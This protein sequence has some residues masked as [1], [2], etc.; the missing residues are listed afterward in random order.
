MEGLFQ[1]HLSTHLS[2]WYR[3]ASL[4]KTR[5][6]S[7]RSDLGGIPNTSYG[8]GALILPQTTS[9]KNQS[10][11]QKASLKRGTKL[12]LSRKVE[13][14]MTQSFESPLDGNY[15]LLPNSSIIT[16]V[17]NGLGKALSL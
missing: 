6:I 8:S 10:S 5:L 7:C 17:D 15:R 12:G 13:F 9:P 3:R 4:R 2:G 14:P 11:R 1:S 16:G